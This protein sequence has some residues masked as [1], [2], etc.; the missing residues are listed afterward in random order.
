M[1]TTGIFE[2]LFHGRASYFTWRSA[3]CRHDWTEWNVVFDQVVT[4]TKPFQRNAEEPAQPDYH[5]APGI[6]PEWR[7][8][9]MAPMA[10]TWN[11]W[12]A[13]AYP[14]DVGT[15]RRWL[16]YQRWCR[17]CLRIEAQYTYKREPIDPQMVYKKIDIC[18]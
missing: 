10:P 6:L 12:L 18:I 14:D 16:L 7:M 2:T 9:P 17:K 4:Q 15:V 11:N 5:V 13:N 3:W 8:E 1:K